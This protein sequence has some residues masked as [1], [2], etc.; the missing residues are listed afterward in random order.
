[1]AG[2]RNVLCTVIHVVGA[3]AIGFDSSVASVV[4]H[5][6]AH[7]T[8]QDHAHADTIRARDQR[9]ICRVL[10]TAENQA[11]TVT[12]A[13]GSISVPAHVPGHVYMDLRRANVTKHDPYFR[14]E[15]DAQTWVR[16]ET[17]VYSLTFD[18]P[19]FEATSAIMHD[20]VFEGIDTVGNVSLNGAFVGVTNN[21]HRTWTFNVS[22]IVQ[23]QNNVLQVTLT[24]ATSYADA[25]ASKYPYSIGD[26]TFIPQRVPNKAFVRKQQSDFGWD[27]GPALVPAG[28]WRPVVFYQYDVVRITNVVTT[29]SRIPTDAST[30]LVCARVHLRLASEAL[31][32]HYVDV[33]VAVGDV[34][35]TIAV[36]T[37]RGGG[38]GDAACGVAPQPDSTTD[39]VVVVSVRV[40]ATDV[41]LWW[42][43]GYGRQPLYNITTSAKAPETHTAYDTFVHTVGFREIDVVE[44]DIT[45]AS[46]P[47]KSFYIRVNGVG[48]FA[49][50]S[51]WIPG[52]AFDNRL[53]DEGLRRLL[54]SATEANQNI[55][56][57]WG[58][59]NYMRDS[60][61]DLCDELGLLVWLDFM[62]GGGR[63]PRNAEH[64]TNWAAEVRQNVRRIAS[65]PCLALYNGNNEGVKAISSVMHGTPVKI[66]GD[67]QAVA[68]MDYAALFD[69]TVRTVVGAEDASRHFHA[70]CPSNGYAV[71]DLDLGMH[72]HRMG[73]PFGGSFGDTRHYDYTSYCLDSSKYPAGR[74]VSEYGWQSYPSLHTLDAVTLPQDRAWNSTWAAHVQHHPDGNSELAVQNAIFFDPP[75]ASSPRH[76]DAFVAQ[77]QAVQALC[78]KTQSEFYRAQRNTTG[79]RTMGCMYWQLNDIW[80]APSW[81]SIEYGGR[82]KALHYHIKRAYQAIMVFPALTGTTAIPSASLDS[83]AHH[84]DVWDPTGARVGIQLVSDLMHA[85]ATVNVSWVLWAWKSDTIVARNSTVVASMPALSVVEVLPSTSLSELLPRGVAATQAVLVVAAG[86]ADPEQQTQNELYLSPF[87]LIDF[88]GKRPLVSITVRVTAQADDGVTIELELHSSALVPLLFVDSPLDGRFSDNSFLMLPTEGQDAV[89]PKMLTFIPWTSSGEPPVD[90]QAFVQTLTATSV[91]RDIEVQVK[92]A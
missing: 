66:T 45:D 79:S 41:S 32:N 64:V 19:G 92:R 73:D 39:R 27:W 49:K 11:W 90:P 51:N 40:A 38:V 4:P 47:G 9:V 86:G 62:H 29:V 88:S 80:Q 56:R 34:N 85:V 74:F 65:H 2:H 70:S 6:R 23:N 13:N 14:F 60:F 59:G 77:T 69:S 83:N 25:H 71:D 3:L 63:S 26:E 24:P 28:I 12:N 82:W 36:G 55:L 10:N 16:N 17:W 1:M 43:T 15:D 21:Q 84:R 50:G 87:K 76:F 57:V 20:L 5:H 78:I 61:W 58:G 48:V 44:D 75:V 54:V 72:I 53:T 81:A 46:N 68:A 91:A 42:P 67:A 31:A 7:V 52:D 35:G 8:P 37:T 18:L 33:T 89:A 22:A 30:W